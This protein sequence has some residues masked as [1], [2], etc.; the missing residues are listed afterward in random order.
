MSN[1]PLKPGPIP[2]VVGIGK[3]KIFEIAVKYGFKP[4]FD[5]LLFA[6]ALMCAFEV[7]NRMTE[8]MTDQEIHDAQEGKTS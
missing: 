4:N 5:T 7:H 3:D 2:Y 6:N 1:K 8:P